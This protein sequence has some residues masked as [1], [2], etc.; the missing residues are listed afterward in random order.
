MANH[1]TWPEKPT[2]GGKERTDGA[3]EFSG[4]NRHRVANVAAFAAQRL[5][6]RGGVVGGEAV[7]AVAAGVAE[8]LLEDVVEDGGGGDDDEGDVGEDLEGEHSG[9]I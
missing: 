1:S 6:G 5:V 8:R 2:R 7:G 3:E 9:S 4:D